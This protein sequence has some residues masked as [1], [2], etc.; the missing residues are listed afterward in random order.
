V[1]VVCFYCAVKQYDLGPL[2]TVPTFPGFKHYED[3]AA[4]LFLL[5]VPADGVQLSPLQVKLFDGLFHGASGAFSLQ[6]AWMTLR[7]AAAHSFISARRFAAESS[8]D[9]RVSG[10][11]T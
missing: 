10:Q 9:R 3:E 4:Q 1:G 7:R 8:T 11:S 5:G 2:D 6:M